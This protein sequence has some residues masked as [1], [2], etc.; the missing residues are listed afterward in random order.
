MLNKKKIQLFLLNLAKWIKMG[1][2]YYF[3]LALLAICFM[4]TDTQ[5]RVQGGTSSLL[6]ELYSAL[7]YLTFKVAVVLSVLSLR[8][9][10]GGAVPAMPWIEKCGQPVALV[11]TLVVFVLRSC[12]ALPPLSLLHVWFLPLALAV[13][14][15]LL[16]WNKWKCRSATQDTVSRTRCVNEKENQSR[17][18]I[19]T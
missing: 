9:S 4:M 2:N 17:K 8:P 6:F 12:P 14:L 15:L 18:I 19:L 5:Q 16:T 13:V 7:V 10:G 3:L 11:S 1:Q